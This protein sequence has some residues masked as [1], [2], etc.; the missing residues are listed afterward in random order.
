MS[1]NNGRWGHRRFVYVQAWVKRFRRSFPRHWERAVDT[2]KER[3]IYVQAWVK[4]FR[5]SFPGT[6]PEIELW[7]FDTGLSIRDLISIF[8]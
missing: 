5:R 4:R 1:V 2:G 3:F 8:P 6:G 7:L